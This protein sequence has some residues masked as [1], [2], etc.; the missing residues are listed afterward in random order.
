MASRPAAD[1]TSSTGPARAEPPPRRSG[2]TCAG[3]YGGGT[4][5]TPD[6]PRAARAIRR[7]TCANFD[8]QNWHITGRVRNYSG[9]GLYL[10]S[11]TDASA[12]TG[13]Q[14]DI[15]GTFTPPAS[16]TAASRRRRSR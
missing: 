16:A 13:C 11:K 5:S 8:G 2:A 1:V 10:T 7:C 14:F 4:Y 6:R 12:F 9:F 15:P 3:T